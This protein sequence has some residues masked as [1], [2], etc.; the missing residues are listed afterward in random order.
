MP[1]AQPYSAISRSVSMSYEALIESTAGSC[2]IGE[3]AKVVVVVMIESVIVVF[4]DIE[5]CVGIHLTIVI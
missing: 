5:V 1:E 3:G 4:E 2:M